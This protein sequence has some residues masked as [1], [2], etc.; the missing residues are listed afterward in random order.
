[1]PAYRQ[2]I[3]IGFRTLQEML[4][5]SRALQFLFQKADG[6]KG[7]ERS[8]GNGNPAEEAQ[9]RVFMYRAGFRPDCGCMMQVRNLPFFSGEG[10]RVVSILSRMLRPGSTRQIHSPQGKPPAVICCSATRPAALRFQLFFTSRL[11]T[12][13]IFRMSTGFA[14]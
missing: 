5:R 8:G 14:K 12:L 9:Q 7:E 10:L 13:N 3:F 1:M 6:R 11:M 2:I 4:E